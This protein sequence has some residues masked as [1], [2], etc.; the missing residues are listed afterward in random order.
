[1]ALLSDPRYHDMFWDNYAV[2]WVTEDPRERQELLADEPCLW[3]ENQLTF[4]NREFKEV[5]PDAFVA[6]PPR[7][8]RVII[9]GLYL[10][11]RE[12]WL[13]EWPLLWWRRRRRGRSAFT[14]RSRAS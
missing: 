14:D 1:V 6:G 3:C 11:R 12:P 10:G 2:E 13:W 8:G 7:Q 4:R 9:R 5:I